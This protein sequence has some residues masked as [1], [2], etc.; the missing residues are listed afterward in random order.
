MFERRTAAREDHALRIALE[1]GAHA[2]TRDISSGG[3][4]LV[5]PPG[6]L[7]DD[8]VRIELPLA[9]A[10]LRMHALGEVLRIERRADGV[11]IALRLHHVRLASDR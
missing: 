5:L 7:L 1:D 10:G 6:H 3:V 4:Y 9:R 2:V 11:G 8:W